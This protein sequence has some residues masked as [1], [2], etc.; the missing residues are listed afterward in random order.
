MTR[1]ATPISGHANSK[2]FWSTFNLCEFVSTSKKSGYFI[3]LLWRYG[4]LKNPAIWLAENILVHISGT[5]F[6]QNMGLCWNTANNTRFHYRTN[7]VK[8]N[9]KISI[10]AKNHVFG[11][12]LIHFPNFLGKKIFPGKSGPVTHNFTSVSST[13]SKFRKN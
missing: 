4:W 11:P 12:F 2:I 10:N 9:D 8:I 13:M 3:D 1:L 6:F 7:S 5:Q